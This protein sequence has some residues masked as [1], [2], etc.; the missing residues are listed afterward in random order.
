MIRNPVP[1]SR[2]SQRKPRSGKPEVEHHERDQDERPGS[3]P[4]IRPGT[5]DRV[6]QLSATKKRDDPERD[7]GS[8]RWSASG[9][10]GAQSETR[11]TASTFASS[12]SPG[13]VTVVERLRPD[14]GSGVDAPGAARLASGTSRLTHAAT[15]AVGGGARAGCPRARLTAFETGVSSRTIVR[16]APRHELDIGAS[17]ASS[18]SAWTDPRRPCCRRRPPRASLCASDTATPG[19]PSSA[20][21]RRR[22]LVAAA[23]RRRARC[24]PRPS[25]PAGRWPRGRGSLSIEPR[26]LSNGCGMPTRPPWARTSS[27]VSRGRPARRHGTLEEQR[28]E[29]PVGGPDLLAHDDRQPSGAA[30]RARSAPSI[31]S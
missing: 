13:P 23:A 19:S 15:R 31:R 14:L 2:S 10:A 18:P 17:A 26:Y 22:L 24:A 30:S 29:I 4:A 25:P 20:R 11:S 7:R 6:C 12:M 21:E 27:I 5:L 3:A 9:G 1:R 16:R 8:R 28:D